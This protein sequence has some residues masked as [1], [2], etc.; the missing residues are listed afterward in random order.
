[1]MFAFSSGQP[2]CCQG[3]Y[4]MLQFLAEL[5]NLQIIDDVECHHMRTLA[6]ATCLSIGFA[7]TP[8]CITFPFSTIM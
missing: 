1:M 8:F 5:F 7:T 6:S 3:A 2:T 4:G